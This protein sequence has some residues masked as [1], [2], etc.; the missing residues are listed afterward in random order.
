MIIHELKTLQDAHGYLPA[1]ELQALARR[2]NVP[3][4]RLHRVA[5]FYPH[6][7]LQP[8]PAAAANDFRSRIGRSTVTAKRNGCRAVLIRGSAGND[9]S[10]ASIYFSSVF[11]T[12]STEARPP[13]VLLTFANRT[14]R[15]LPIT[16]VEG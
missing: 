8:P 16:N 11:S 1:A 3:L 6:F 13:C 7:R 14:F 5:S 2:L 12:S 9:W 4:Y 10:G 15:S